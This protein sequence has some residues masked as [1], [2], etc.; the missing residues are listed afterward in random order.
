VG[1]IVKVANRTIA[2]EV[3]R[4]FKMPARLFEQ[5]PS[6]IYICDRDGLVLRY[7]RRAVELWG[8]S[9]K[10][11]DPNE[12]FCGSYKMFRPDG[13]LLPHHEC[14]MADVLRTGIS[15]RQQEVHIERPDGSRGIALV[16][17]EAIKDGDETIVGAVNCF[18]DIT[19]R[20]QAEQRDKIFA[21][22]VDHRAKN[23]LTLVQATVHLTR[24]DTVEGLKAAIEGR[25]QALS[26]A[27]TLLAKSRWAGANLHT[28]ITEELAPYNLTPYNLKG[29][30][31]A[32]I[33][34]SE[35]LLE[36]K[37][38][39][40][41]AMV[42]HE[43]T[44]NAVKYGALSVPSGRVRVEWS[45]GETQLVIRWSEAGGP[46]V[47]PPIHQGFGTRVFDGVVKSE[48][49]GTL[50]FDWKPDGLACEMVVPLDQLARP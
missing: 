29:I 48:L 32:Q 7:N 26:N 13:N 14:P 47:K 8:R 2:D 27:H 19:E 20:R 12:R 46:P 1:D 35:I 21:R 22:E 50:H 33:S 43:L 36:P 39:Q 25:L 44:T 4:I 40:A 9:P 24:A 34:G 17:I 11:G 31:R 3:A 42:L 28:L 41:M 15:V 23:L 37:S 5:L 6:A 30:V 49:Q 38:A 18:Q 10:L 16:D 45:R